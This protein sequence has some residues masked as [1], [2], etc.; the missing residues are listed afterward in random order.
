MAYGYGNEHSY[1]Q[2]QYGRDYE[3][4]PYSGL[5]AFDDWMDGPGGSAQRGGDMFGQFGSAL[6]QD[7]ESAK[8]RGFMGREQQEAALNLMLDEG[9]YGAMDSL[10]AQTAEGRQYADYGANLQYDQAMESADAQRDAIG[11]YEQSIGG[12]GEEYGQ[13]ADEMYGRG[14]RMI[15]EQDMFA[16]DILGM[17]QDRIEEQ[18]ADTGD[19][20]LARERIEE[21]LIQDKLNQQEAAEQSRMNEMAVK[22][23]LDRDLNDQINM[24]R[25]DDRMTPEMQ[26]DAINAAKSMHSSKTYESIGR[27]ENERIRLN[28]QLGRDV[29]QGLRVASN[30]YKGIQDS[31]NTRAA[32]HNQTLASVSNTVAN[33]RSSARSGAAG[34]YNS[35]GQLTA[36]GIE[37]VNDARKT[38][39]NARMGV[40]A[41][42]NQNIAGIASAWTGQQLRLTE[43]K[44]KGEQFIRQGLGAI[45]TMMANLSLPY[46][47]AASFMT[48]AL[49]FYSGAKAGGIDPTQ[50]GTALNWKNFSGP[51]PMD[52]MTAW[53]SPMDP[54]WDPY[55]MNKPGWRQNRSG[56]SGRTIAG[57]MAREGMQ[58]NFYG[59]YG[60]QEGMMVPMMT[61]EYGNRVRAYRRRQPGFLGGIDARGGSR[62][63]PDRWDRHTNPNPYIPPGP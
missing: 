41:S 60:A 55:G 1:G 5:N 44:T 23:S 47:E 16:Q 45:G 25:S 22:R 57:E 28:A 52:Y 43:M 36:R 37:A 51:N 48:K 9:Y 38:V 32:N 12:M 20:D 56:T 4:D 17:M 31:I 35:A 27:M 61:D 13:A 26:E 39:L 8:M 54:D 10:G 42:L 34:L 33:I 18:E 62:Y 63:T 46:V 59:N 58:T 14:D 2:S 21:S 6:Y 15:S 3:W 11:D 49:E 19:Y 50:Q 29:S 24:I 30:T 40:E 7:F 53:D